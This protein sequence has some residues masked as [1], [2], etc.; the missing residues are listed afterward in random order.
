[1]LHIFKHERMY[2]REDQTFTHVH[3]HHELLFCLEGSGYEFTPG[4]KRLLKANDIFLYPAGMAHNSCSRNKEPYTCVVLAFNESVLQEL[5]ETSKP[6]TALTTMLQ[7]IRVVDDAKLAVSFQ[8]SKRIR[9]LLEQLLEKQFQPDDSWERRLLFEQILLT[10]YQSFGDKSAADGAGD[11]HDIIRN[12]CDFL[13][14]QFE[15]PIQV[16]DILDFCPLSRSHFFVLFKQ[17]TGQTFNHYLINVRLNYACKML[18]E[19]GASIT[20]IAYQCGFSS[21]SHFCYTFKKWQQQSPTE[22][23]NEST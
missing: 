6:L 15:K 12:V 14:S 5:K 21:Y 10:A 16:D 23:R 1:M 2:G 11:N 4:K 7:G 8:Q 9:T 22:Y 3:K 17:V 19:S 20:E 13:D 18:K